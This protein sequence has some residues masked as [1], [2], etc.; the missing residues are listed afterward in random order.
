M[1]YEYECPKC[2]S[3]IEKILKVA[4]CDTVEIICPECKVRCARVPF[5]SDFAVHY[6]GDGWYCKDSKPLNFN[7]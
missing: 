4:E 5:S 6:K 1:L 3:K 2:G 7:D